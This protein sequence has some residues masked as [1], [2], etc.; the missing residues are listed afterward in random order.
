[1]KTILLVEDNEITRK[2]F[3]V[4]L[5][6]AGWS[7]LEAADG[8]QALALASAHAPGLVLQDLRLPDMSGFELARRLRALPHG[9]TTTIIAVSSLLSSREEEELAAPVPSLFPDAAAVLQ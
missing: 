2:L 8:R 6:G 3:R 4:T 5:Q 1:M 7:V 9:A